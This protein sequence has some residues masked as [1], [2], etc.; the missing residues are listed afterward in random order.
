M[1][2]AAVYGRS[3]SGHP[4]KH[5][6]EIALVTKSHFLRDIGNS[7]VGSGQKEL[8]ALHA[9]VIQIVSERP[10]SHLLEEIHEVRLGQAAELRRVRYLDCFS[11]MLT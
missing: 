5:R 8:R 11:N 2:T 4:V 6:A 9:A 10:A 3:H 1:M 7:P